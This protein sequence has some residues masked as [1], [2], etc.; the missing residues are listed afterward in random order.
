M[1]VLTEVVAYVRIRLKFG[2]DPLLDW[3]R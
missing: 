3:K 2:S 1:S